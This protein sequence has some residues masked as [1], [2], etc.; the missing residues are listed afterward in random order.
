MG[1]QVGYLAGLAAEQA[2]ARTYER[3]GRPILASRWRGQG[4]EIDLV[5]QQDDAV[6]FVEVKK[7]RS[8]D[9]ALGRVSRRQARRIMAAAS[10]Y[11]GTLATGQLT[12]MRFDVATVDET[13]DVR[14]LENAFCE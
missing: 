3:M 2:V 7:A 12:H 11:V 8:H 13:G 6:V 9:L 4:G 10:E 1:G 14:L 5:A